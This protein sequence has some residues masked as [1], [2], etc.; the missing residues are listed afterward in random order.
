MHGIYPTGNHVVG[1]VSGSEDYDIMKVSCKELLRRINE[2]AGLERWDWVKRQED[3]PGILLIWWLQG[4]SNNG[5]I[6]IDDN[7][8]LHTQN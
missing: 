2:L 4:S 8:G 1:I 7:I 3:T 5:D 6:D